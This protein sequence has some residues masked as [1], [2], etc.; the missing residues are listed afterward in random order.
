MVGR[1]NRLDRISVVSFDDGVMGG[2]STDAGITLRTHKPRQAALNGSSSA[3][4]VPPPEDRA[5]KKFD[6]PSSRSF[7]M[8]LK[9][10]GSQTWAGKE[11]IY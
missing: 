1:S 9:S 11:E 8:R 4:V 2:D 3:P 6:I 10:Q 7:P 5:G